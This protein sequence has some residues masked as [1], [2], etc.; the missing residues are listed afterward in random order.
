M[1]RGNPSTRR[2][3]IVTNS[4]L[5]TLESDAAK[6][7]QQTANSTQNSQNSGSGPTRK[8]GKKPPGQE[9]NGT[10]M[11]YP[12]SAFQPGQDMLKISIFEY[13]PNPNALG[14]I[15]SVTGPIRIPANAETATP[16][17]DQTTINFNTSATTAYNDFFSN[18]DAET[19]GRLK[20][21]SR[22]IYLPIPQQISDSLSVGY[23][24]DTMSP[25]DA[26]AGGVAMAAAQGGDMGAGFN[27]VKDIIGN[28]AQNPNSLQFTGIDESAIMA[29]KTG[30]ASQVVNLAGRNISANQLLSRAS[31]Q[32]F[33]SNLELLFSSVTLRSFPF[34]FDF[35]PRDELEA[36]EVK[37]IIKTIKYAMSPS[38]GGDTGGSGG[39]LLGSPDLFTFTYLS[40]KN[41]HPFLNRFKVGVLTDMKVNYTASG[42]YATYAGALKSPVHMRM[43]LTFKEINPI[44]QQDYDKLGD[45]APGV[46]Y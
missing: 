26:A 39:I 1:A 28:F 11:R 46:G 25:I 18:V 30:L 41:N 15:D 29:L 4:N 7:S 44:Y 34:V 33:Q 21:N 32:I 14:L 31:G 36:D 27:R 40:G 19:K 2:F 43:Q 24:E 45:A 20:K 38:N 5:E 13:E 12:Y 37:K 3:D 9:Q 8:P 35:A 23:S 17:Y 16:A 10:V 6:Q 42:T 22:H